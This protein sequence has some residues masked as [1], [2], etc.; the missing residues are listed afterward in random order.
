MLLQVRE[1]ADAIGHADAPQPVDPRVGVGRE[2]GVVLPRHP[3]QLDRALLDQLVQA[4]D[5]IAG[6]AEN[7]LD[8]QGAEPLDQVLPI[9]TVAGRC[10]AGRSVAD[11]R[12]WRH[13]VSS[14]GAKCSTSWSP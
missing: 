4:Q 5:V 6:D 1:P 7:V 11:R 13:P 14:T 12:R 2:P 8:A 9:V 10:R 3:D